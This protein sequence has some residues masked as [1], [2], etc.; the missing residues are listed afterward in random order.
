M[1]AAT[2]KIFSRE[3]QQWPWKNANRS[4]D[5]AMPASCAA[6][7]IKSKPAEHV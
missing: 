7:C 4:E 2:R 3:Q 6:A 1:Q 5:S